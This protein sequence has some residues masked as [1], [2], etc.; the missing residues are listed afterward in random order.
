MAK[1]SVNANVDS[2]TKAQTRAL[3]DA[4]NTAT[5]SHKDIRATLAKLRSDLDVLELKTSLNVT[6]NPFSV[7]FGSLDGVNVTGVW[8]EPMARIEF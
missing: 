1:G 6:K 2:Y 4:H 5:D 8:D 3:I 7:T